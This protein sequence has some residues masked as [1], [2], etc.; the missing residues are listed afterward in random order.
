MRTVVRVGLILTAVAALLALALPAP[1]RYIPL[2][3]STSIPID[4]Q[5]L[6]PLA[7]GGSVSNL[8][9]TLD[10]VPL[11]T[12]VDWSALARFGDKPSRHV[13]LAWVVLPTAGP[14]RSLAEA[15]TV[16]AQ[17]PGDP[18]SHV[19]MVEALARQLTPQNASELRRSAQAGARL[20]PRNMF[21]RLA[22]AASAAASGNLE[23][24]ASISAACA[25]YDYNPH[26]TE[27][28]DALITAARELGAPEAKAALSARTII[29]QLPHNAMIRRLA[30]ILLESP[31]FRSN[32]ELR[33]AWLKIGDAVRRREASA[34]GVLNGAAVQEMAS[35]WNAN[36]LDTALAKTGQARDSLITARQRVVASQQRAFI[37]SYNVTQPAW[38]EP[39]MRASVAWYRL[40]VLLSGLGLTIAVGVA[41][42][43]ASSFLPQPAPQAGRYLGWAAAVAALIPAVSVFAVLISTAKAVW[44]NLTALATLQVTPELYSR[45]TVG[46][47]LLMVA[48]AAA[49]ALG[50][51]RAAGRMG[52]GRLLAR[53][54][55]S[56]APALVG[57]LLCA[58]VAVSQVVAIQE[59]AAAKLTRTTLEKG[60]LQLVE[61][62]IQK[63]LGGG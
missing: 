60:E 55:A 21:F 29:A 7:Q 25:D 1:R 10:H 41:A 24:A 52:F 53:I 33:R 39:H 13:R 49:A 47:P 50:I 8:R 9:W 56:A 14:D 61:Q 42:A 38:L 20:E 58:V 40:A 27:L 57:L 19:A 46:I 15:K 36:T 44:A 51:N 37:S 11:F 31:K 30:S 62:T 43:I 54:T 12:N 6:G 4:E 5:A 2:A 48:V 28:A 3:V 16:L 26:E 18:L 32:L 22:E 35:A 17:A 45:W 63:S 59:S 34:Q 23:E